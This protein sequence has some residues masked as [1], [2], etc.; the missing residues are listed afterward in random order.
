MRQIS[1][2]VLAAGLQMSDGSQPDPGRQLFQKNC[3]RCHGADGTKGFLGAKNL[4]KSLLADE[5][6][7]C[8][9]RHG[10]RFMPSF[11]K[12]LTA[13]EIEQLVNYVKTLRTN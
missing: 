3:I 13:A 12:R 5:A 9:I 4:Q 11:Q 6:I 8:R 10:K 1:I 7:T 2:W